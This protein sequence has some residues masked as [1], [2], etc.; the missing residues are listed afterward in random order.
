MTNASFDASHSS[1]E[2]GNLEWLEP[3]GSQPDGTD[4]RRDSRRGAGKQFRLP[5]SLLFSSFA[6]T[7]KGCAKKEKARNKLTAKGIFTVSVIEVICWFLAHLTVFS[8]MD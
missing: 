2:D 3:A 8:T 4:T 1:K 7:P 5:W 6:R